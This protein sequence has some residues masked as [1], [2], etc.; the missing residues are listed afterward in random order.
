MLSK[1]KMLISSIYYTFLFSIRNIFLIRTRK[2]NSITKKHPI[3]VTLT[4]YPKRINTVFL[5]I[6]SIFSQTVSPEK[7]ILWLYKEDKTLIPNS[8]KRLQKRGLEIHF[9]DEDLRSYKKLSYTNNFFNTHS[10]V[11]A[12]DDILYPKNWLE[13]LYNESLKYPNTVIC[14]RGHDISISNNEIESYSTFMKNKTYSTNPSSLL[15]PTGCSGI[16]YPIGSLSIDASYKN[17]HIFMQLAPDAD[18]FWYKFVCLKNGFLAKRVHSE[19]KHFPPIISSL[20]D[21]LFHNNVRNNQ[22]DK[23]LLSTINYFELYDFIIKK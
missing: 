18:D 5:T 21:G 4:T 11:T 20:K 6:E 10:I 17:S 12:D 19:N 9:C 22:N 2:N 15:I 7:V 13:E 23:K 3:I 1:L 8:L 14:H 16:L